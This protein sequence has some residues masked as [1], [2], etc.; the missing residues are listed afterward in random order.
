MSTICRSFLVLSFLAGFA[1]AQDRGTIRGTVTDPSGAAVPEA[2][3][4]IRN[5]N[6]GLTQTAQTA[7]DGAYSALYLPVGTYTVTTQKQGFQK[8]EAS[9]VSVNVNTV[10]AVD[11]TLTVGSIDQKVEVTSQAPML[12][13]QGANL[14]RIMDAKTLED[15]PLTIGG[16]MRSTTA[17]IQLMPGVLGSSGDNRIAGGLASGESY[18]LDGSE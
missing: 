9:N 14:G 10:S 6:T 8:A 15:L 5:V 18:R 12:E 17:F 7:A 13:T 3:V 16:G 2:T 11:I 4:T 1:L